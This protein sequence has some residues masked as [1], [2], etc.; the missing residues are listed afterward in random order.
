MVRRCPSAKT[1]GIMGI[2]ILAFNAIYLL[3]VPYCTLILTVAVLLAKLGS[4]VSAIDE[5]KPPHA[6][7][8]LERR[9]PRSLS[10]NVVRL[11]EVA[12]RF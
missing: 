11:S 2:L 8:S 3:P 12:M 1:N 6:T 10:T 5:L 9:L 7:A 4:G